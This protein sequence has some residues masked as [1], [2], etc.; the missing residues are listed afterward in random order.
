MIS[1]AMGKLDELKRV[2]LVDEIVAECLDAGLRRDN[3]GVFFRPDPRNPFTPKGLRVAFELAARGSCDDAIRMA[4]TYIETQPQDAWY[5]IGKC[6]CLTQKTV[7]ANL[8]IDKLKSSPS[9]KSALINACISMGFDYA[10][11][12]VQIKQ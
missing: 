6:G 1:R 8:A 12:K 11:G 9:V 2:D 3:K 7:T 10:Q 4:Q 5:T